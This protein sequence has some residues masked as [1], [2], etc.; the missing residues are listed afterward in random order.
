MGIRDFSSPNG[1]SWKDVN[2]RARDF[3]YNDILVKYF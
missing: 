1:E 3:I 2:A